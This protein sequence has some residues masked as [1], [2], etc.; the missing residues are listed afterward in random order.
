[1]NNSNDDYLV[2][3]KSNEIGFDLHFIILRFALL[4]ASIVILITNA[5]LLHLLRRIATIENVM[6]SVFAWFDLLIDETLSGTH[7]PTSV[8]IGGNVYNWAVKQSNE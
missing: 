4:F 6:R 7:L 5:F 3:I 2:C 8:A 1:M